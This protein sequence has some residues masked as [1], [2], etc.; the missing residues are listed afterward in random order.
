MTQAERLRKFKCLNVNDF[1][2]NKGVKVFH[3]EKQIRKRTSYTF[4]QPIVEQ[5]ANKFPPNKR[6]EMLQKMWNQM[7]D[8]HF[9]GS[10]T[11]ANYDLESLA[12]CTKDCDN[13]HWREE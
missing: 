9:F 8:R 11:Q 7:D 12:L 5:V 2:A 10:F 6:N 1:F 13:G 3:S 4:W